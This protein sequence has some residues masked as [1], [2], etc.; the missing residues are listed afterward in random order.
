MNNTITPMNNINFQ[1]K[2]IIADLDGNKARLQNIVK[3]FEQKTKNFPN[4]TVILS[5]SFGKNILWERFNNKQ[6][7]IEDDIILQ[8]RLTK[9]LKKLSDTEIAKKFVSIL[10]F[11]N[12]Q[13]KIEQDTNRLADSLNLNKAS[14]ETET[15]FYDLMAKLRDSR[16]AEFK[17]KNPIFQ[18]GLI[19]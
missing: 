1:A 12:K 3:I 19:I 2:L 16:I 9:A 17:E 8:P 15:K 18:K 11:S 6:N 5:G 4:D 10:K 7:W 13:G 14:L